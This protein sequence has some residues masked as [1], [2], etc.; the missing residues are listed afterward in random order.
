MDLFFACFPPRVYSTKKQ[1]LK[2]I[3]CK[4]S[5]VS[6]RCLAVAGCPRV[7]AYGAY[8]ID[9]F[10]GPFREGGGKR[11]I[12]PGA[13]TKGGGGQ[14]MIEIKSEYLYVGRGGKGQGA[15]LGGLFMNA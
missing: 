2:T 8:P 7:N 12:C 4:Q 10:T 13:Q 15:T 11:D 9:L 14:T 1:R 5:L 3:F 6:V